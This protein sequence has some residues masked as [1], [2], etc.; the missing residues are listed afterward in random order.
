MLLVR[1]GLTI[2]GS[3]DQPV[4][5]RPIEPGQPFGAVAVVG[6]GSERTEVTYLEL[7]GGSDAWLDG[8]Q[9]VGRAVDSLSGPGVGVPHDDSRQSGR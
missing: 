7:S 4:T 2:S 5:I 3:A 9:F 8:A 6:D 1:G